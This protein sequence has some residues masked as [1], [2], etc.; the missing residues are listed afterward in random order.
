ML[1]P[2]GSALQREVEVH[3]HQATNPLG[4]TTVVDTRL[5]VRDPGRCASCLM[6]LRLSYIYIRDVRP[7][8]ING[9]G[10]QSSNPCFRSATRFLNCFQQLRAVDPT[11]SPRDSNSEGVLI[12]AGTLHK[13]FTP[14]AADVEVETLVRHPR[15]LTA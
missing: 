15:S 3:A 8:A 4:A 2:E 9:G 11:S 10:D 12:S 13:A 7:D 14:H 1:R 5:D 6:P